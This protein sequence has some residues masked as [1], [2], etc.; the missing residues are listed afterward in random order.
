MCKK[1]PEEWKVKR[2]A[3]ARVKTG[4][5]EMED[6]FQMGMKLSAAQPHSE[7]H[8]SKEE[9]QKMLGE[10]KDICGKNEIAGKAGRGGGGKSKGA[11]VQK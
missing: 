10:A 5:K 4:L 7:M 11:R 3:E 9:V 2:G 6:G 1:D 8:V